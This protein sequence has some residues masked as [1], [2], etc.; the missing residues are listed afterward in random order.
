MHFNK[1][2][3]I[4]PFTVYQEKSSFMFWRGEGDTWKKRDEVGNNRRDAY[5][6]YNNALPCKHTFPC[7]ELN[8]TSTFREIL[9]TC[10][11]TPAVMT[12]TAGRWA[13]PDRAGLCWGTVGLPKGSLPS[14]LREQTAPIP[15]NNILPHLKDCFRP[16]RPSIFHN[17]SLTSYPIQ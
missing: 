6:D 11:P 14:S 5:S 7:C 8:K 12:V 16:H 3:S 9:H 15:T 10:P 17:A 4:S 13:P 2:I 1:T